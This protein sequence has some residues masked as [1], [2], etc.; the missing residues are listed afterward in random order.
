MQKTSGC[1]MESL[2]PSNLSFYTAFLFIIP[3]IYSYTTLQ[4]KDITVA[5]LFFTITSA[6]NHYY[7]CQDSIYQ[8]I[9]RFTVRVV[10]VMYITYAIIH[11]SS[12]A[13]YTLIS[14]SLIVLASYTYIAATSTKDVHD[15]HFLI[16]FVGNLSV[17][18]FI[19]YRKEHEQH[20]KKYM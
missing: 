15:A 3:A 8:K 1:K 10:A 19:Y 6:L 14:L 17:M 9:D 16:H 2:V 20:N 18:L 13:C 4:K 11:F 7:R 12:K 5:C